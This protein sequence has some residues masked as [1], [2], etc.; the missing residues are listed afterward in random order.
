MKKLLAD[1]NTLGYKKIKVVLDRGF[2]SAANINDLYKHH[3]KFL[4]AAKLSLNFVKS[5]L[6]TVQ[7]QMRSWTHY[8]QPYQLYAYNPLPVTWS[9]VQKR[10]CKG[11]TIKAGR[12][13]YLPSVLF[14]GTSIRG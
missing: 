12:R 3:I 8:S 10:P 11:D 13:M 5:H 1:M 2:F 14:P 9:Y 4:I 7:D 6:D